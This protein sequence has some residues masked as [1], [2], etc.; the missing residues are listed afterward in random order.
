MGPSRSKFSRAY[1][2]AYADL[3]GVDH[4]GTEGKSLILVV[5][6]RL[7]AGLLGPRCSAD[8]VSHFC[9]HGRLGIQE[10]TPFKNDPSP[11]ADFDFPSRLPPL[12]E[13][14]DTFPQPG[15]AALR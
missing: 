4:D 14:V 3:L 2:L 1:I 9:L 15:S 8:Q 6:D 7:P 13:A 5:H 10:P 11:L 12:P